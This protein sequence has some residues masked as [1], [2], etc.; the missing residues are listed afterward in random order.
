MVSGASARAPVI[1]V[2][3]RLVEVP[4]ALLSVFGGPVTTEG[5]EKAH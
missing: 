2:S 1:C 4:I 5:P 3:G